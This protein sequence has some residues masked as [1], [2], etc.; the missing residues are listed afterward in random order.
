MTGEKVLEDAR[1]LAVYQLGLH[2]RH[3]ALCRNAVCFSV[4]LAWPPD[5]LALLG[6]NAIA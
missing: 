6:D 5:L 3:V 2:V 4:A 1:L